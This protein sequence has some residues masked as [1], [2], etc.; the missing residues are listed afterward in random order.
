MIW[1]YCRFLLFC[2]LSNFHVHGSNT[3]I[4]LSKII[5]LTILNLMYITLSFIQWNWMNQDF[6]QSLCSSSHLIITI[7]IIIIIIITFVSAMF[8]L[9]CRL[10]L[11]SCALLA[12]RRETVFRENTNS[13]AKI[14]PTS[15]IAKKKM[16]ILNN[17][18]KNRELNN[19]IHWLINQI[20][21]KK[22][23]IVSILKQKLAMKNY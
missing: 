1:C 18:T 9:S 21:S 4:V 15:N 14:Y 23:G 17:K 20:E 13:R 16:Q 19:I 22:S 12:W 10:M 5:L 6:S 3:F 8:S 7:I 11:F 2:F